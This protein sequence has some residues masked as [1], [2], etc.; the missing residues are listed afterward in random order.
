MQSLRQC[1]VTVA[2]APL[3]SGV[4]GLWGTEHGVGWEKG[5]LPVH[6]DLTLVVDSKPALAWPFVP[7]PLTRSPSSSC[8]SPKEPGD[9]LPLS[10]YTGY[11][12]GLYGR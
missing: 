8:C 10:R 5:Y 6:P 2:G 7:S 1:P 9:F 4:G 3:C 12:R 11:S